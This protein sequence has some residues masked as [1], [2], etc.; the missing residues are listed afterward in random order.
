MRRYL[1]AAT[2]AALAVTTVG[3]P[4]FAATTQQKAGATQTFSINP[5][6]LRVIQNPAPLPKINCGFVQT[7]KGYL[8]PCTGQ[9]IPFFG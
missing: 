8:N 7:S 5:N 1:I 3:V 9:F 2:L 6:S 4:S